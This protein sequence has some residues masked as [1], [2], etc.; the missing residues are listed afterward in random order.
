MASDSL[1][2]TSSCLEFPARCEFL[3]GLGM[4]LA[5]WCR[6]LQR[7]G[8]EFLDKPVPR[9]PRGSMRIQDGN[10]LVPWMKAW[11]GLGL[12]WWIE[13]HKS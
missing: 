13:A 3:L 10:Y 4:C 1:E 11:L 5:G 6:Y 7:L 8:Q 2:F 9:G 12:N